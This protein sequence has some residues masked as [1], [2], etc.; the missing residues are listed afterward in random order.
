MELKKY[1]KRVLDRVRDYARLVDSVNGN[2][3]EAYEE[4]LRQHDL[5]VGEGQ[6][7][8]YSADLGT[9]PKVCI[10]VPTGGGKTFIA[11]NA[12]KVL[13]DSLPPVRARAVVWLVPRKEILRQTIRKL[14]DPADDL[15]IAIDRDF[16]HRVEV[17]DKEQGLTGRGLD[18]SSV[19]DQ[20]TIFVLSYDSFKNKEGRKAYQ[21]NSALM[22]LTNYQKASGM[23]VDVEGADDTALI[24]AL[25][26]LKPIVVVDESHHAKSDLSLGML[27]N[28]NPR[29]VL[30]LTATP[31]SKSN[32]IARVS[33]LE[34]KK[35]QM[36]KLP[37]IVYRRDGKREV[38]EDAIL[39]QRRLELIACREQEKTGRYIRPIVLFQ[40][41]RRGTDDAETFRRLKEK[42]VAAGIPDEQIAIRTGEVDELKN[43]D[44]KSTECP[45][46]FIIT[47]EALSEGWDCPFAYVL[48]TVANKQSKTNVEQ[49]VGRVLRQPYAVRAKTSALNI[50]Y[51]LTSSAD[52]NETIDQVVA[53][54][55]GAGFSKNDVVAS[56]TA[57]E[58]NDVQ[59]IQDELADVHDDGS[60]PDAGHEH[61][62]LDGM[63]FSDVASAMPE[64]ANESDGPKGRVDQ[65]IAESAK[66]EEDFEQQVEENGDHAFDEEDS[67][68]RE[69]DTMRYS[70]RSAVEESVKGLK[71]PRFM[72]RQQSSGSNLFAELDDGDAA[73]LDAASL[74][75]NF[76]A[77]RCSTQG[78][79]FSP[80]A[81]R[82]AKQI[83]VDSDSHVRV[84]WM[85]ADQM[86]M[87]R[88]LFAKDATDNKRR[89]I[90]KGMLDNMRVQARKLYGDGELKR[91]LRNVVEDMD[92][93]QLNDAYD[94]LGAYARIVG[95]EV[96]RQA[97]KFKQDEFNRLRDT[98]TVYLDPCYELPVSFTLAKPF[99]SL[100]NSLYEAEES[101]MNNLER[102]MADMLANTG[103]I[104]WWHRIT[105]NRRGEF[106]I[107]G[108]INHYPDFLAMTRHG[109]VLAIETKGEMLKNDDSR[110]KLELGNIWANMAGGGYRYFMVFKNDPLDATGAYSANEFKTI[111]DQ[112]E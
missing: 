8:N 106:S 19:N 46:R 33:A 93:E 10:K 86:A 85:S 35:E 100:P 13:D 24:S 30:E 109:K 1:Q 91:L 18:V 103:N 41:E 94:N 89:T 26:G 12:L 37:V 48:A 53:G 23:A 112:I 39:L 68:L 56:Q 62:D 6:V 31:S 76:H 27:H 63:V 43:V 20:L 5:H 69:E 49:I 54:L 57:E 105:E 82:D 45:I 44:L 67:G 4:Y 79:R 65:I 72:I 3:P 98:G 97:A 15:R 40:A 34:L 14:R 102:D 77:G 25:A 17:L 83:D 108:F 78:I 28:L 73:E 66:A 29:F 99:D 101:N 75:E 104:L 55:N 7:R 74:L 92:S 59:H 22:Q 60:E 110:D 52:F 71:L 64:T 36:V 50:S 11:A 51:V 107:N 16:S 88:A 2:G 96:D 38:V 84:K 61:D 70:I 21:E 81:I 87:T 32:V 111:L 58:S 47:V 95:D 90:C 42:I 9:V 80:Q